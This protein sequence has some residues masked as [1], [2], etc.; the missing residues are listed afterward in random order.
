MGTVYNLTAG[1]GGGIRLETIAITAPPAKTRYLAGEAFDPA[2]MVV[3]A[4]YSN[5]AALAATGYAVE[6]SGPLADGVEAVTVRYTEGGRSAAALQPVTVLPRLLGISV[7]TPP[8]RTEYQVGEVFDPAGMAVSA[9]YSDGSTRAVEGWTVPTGPFTA[10]GDQEVAVES[11]EHGV[12]ATTAGAVTVARMVIGAAPS[13]SGSLT[14]TGEALSPEWADYDPEQL[15]L[16]GVVS[17]VGAGTYAAAFTPT[18]RY[19]WSDGSTGTRSVPW[20]IGKAA[21]RLTL[22]P[23]E[24]TLSAAAPT[25]TIQADRAG[26]GAVSAVSSDESIAVVEVSGTTVAVSSV[27]QTSGGAVVTVR[28]EED[29][30]HLAVSGT[31]RVT[32]QFTMVYGAEWDGSSSTK[33]TRTD[34]AALFTDPVAAVGDGAGSSP[35]DDI[36]PWSGMKKVTDGENVLVAIPKYWVKVSHVPFRVQI[37]NGPLEGYQVS[38][39]HR[40][41]EDGVGERDVVYIGR[42]E[43]DDYYMSRSGQRQKLYTGLST[44]R[45]GIHSL[46]TDYWQADFAL[47]LTWWF[48]YLVEFSDWDGQAVIGLGI[49]N[50]NAAAN[51][52]GS[53]DSM[54]Y[55]TGRAAGTNGDTAV[56]YRGIE[57]PWGNVSE[58]RDGIIFSDTNICT[59]NNPANFKDTYDG[60]GAVVR[61]NKRATPGG[62]IKA[63]GYDASDPSFIYPSEV[64]GSYNTFVPDSIFYGN[65]IVAPIFGGNYFNRDGYNAGPFFIVD[66]LAPNTTSQRYTICSRIMKLPNPA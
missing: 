33:L 5:G 10:P 63:W 64:G 4:A 32:A 35:F 7:E 51:K 65:G 29:E 57:N 52:T 62:W 14:Y 21:G 17:A 54:T 34:A 55:H 45:T 1:G 25:G 50:T 3:T 13:Q 2:G 39:A 43:C 19:Q 48:L 61:S 60:T 42:Y 53:T 41:R 30:N 20:T 9:A 58:W 47:Q 38:P 23:A 6:P 28:V 66:F 26:S 37:A 12:T 31:C 46:G 18:E 40:D 27:G 24:L 59:Y 16:G 44:F 11:A 15:T 36:M 49:V 22:T 56:Q 8:A